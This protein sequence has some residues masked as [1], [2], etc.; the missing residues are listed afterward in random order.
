LSIYV[1]SGFRAFTS[2]SSGILIPFLTL[3]GTNEVFVQEFDTKFHIAS[4]RPFRPEDFDAVDHPPPNPIPRELGQAGL[5]AFRFGRDVVVDEVA[6][7]QKRLSSTSDR[8]NWSSFLRL[9]ASLLVGDSDQ[10]KDAIIAASNEFK[11]HNSQQTWMALELD[12][13]TWGRSTKTYARITEVPPA[14]I[15]DFDKQLSALLDDPSSPDWPL[16]WRRL[17]SKT[18]DRRLVTAAV[19][20]VAQQPIGRPGLPEVLQPALH[21]SME[22]DVLR[23][24]AMLWLRQE[25]FSLIYWGL[26]WL[27]L[28]SKYSGSAPIAFME[29]EAFRFLETTVELADRRSVDIWSRVWNRIRNR[30]NIS[31]RLVTLA[32]RVAPFFSHSPK[33]IQSVLAHLITYPFAVETLVR[34]LQS[35]A[36]ST[37]IWADV[38]IRLISNSNLNQELLDMGFSWLERNPNLNRWKAVWDVLHSRTKDQKRLVQIAREWLERAYPDILVWPEVMAAIIEAGDVSAVEIELAAQWLSSHA[39]RHQTKSYHRLA[40]LVFKTSSLDQPRS[41]IMLKSARLEREFYSLARDSK[42][43]PNQ[44]PPSMHNLQRTLLE[45]GIIDSNAASILSE[46]SEIRNATA[47]SREESLHWDPAASRYDELFELAMREIQQ[48]RSRLKR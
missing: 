48:A 1:L 12:A 18:K 21:S 16:Q 36:Q 6:E 22:N 23:R 28:N 47:H 14:K 3:R 43:L 32:E 29:E 44:E 20:W 41:R 13:S 39:S 34:W 2:N 45:D 9:E 30:R 8:G 7:L 46:L 11:N 37:T 31:L 4:F 5:M 38:Y 35:S 10:I 15:T 19:Q 17:F 33:F 24:S 25:E 26:I 40:D 27:D 42:I